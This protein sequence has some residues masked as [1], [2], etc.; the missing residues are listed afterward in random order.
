VADQGRLAEARDLLQ[1]TVA[2]VPANV[3][4]R[5]DL[6]VLLLRLRQPREAAAQF[7]MV[8]RAAPD[9]LFACLILGRARLGAGDRAGALQAVQRGLALAPGDPQLR[10]LLAELNRPPGN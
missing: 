9:H 8:L 1:A 3:D 6:G 4:F 10:A 7:E 5:A 2:R